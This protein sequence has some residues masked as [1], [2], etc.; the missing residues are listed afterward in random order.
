MT[1]AGDGG[2]GEGL[3]ADGISCRWVGEPP[4]SSLLQKMKAEGLI[5]NVGSRNNAKWYLVSGTV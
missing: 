5:N 4:S 1:G 3:M 2:A